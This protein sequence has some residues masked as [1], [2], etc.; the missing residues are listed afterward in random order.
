MLLPVLRALAVALAVAGPG[1]L[2]VAAAQSGTSG[3]LGLEVRTPPPVVHP[4]GAIEA[5]RREAEQ[6]AAFVELMLR[7]QELARQLQ[8]EAATPWRG[9]RPNLDPDVTGGIQARNLG[10]ALG[11]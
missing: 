11:P 3:G 10:R 2:G 9:R 5:T 6:E 7:Q 4:P 8:R 1:V